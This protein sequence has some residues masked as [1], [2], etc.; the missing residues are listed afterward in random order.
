MGWQHE[1]GPICHI[2]NMWF[3]HLWMVVWP[4]HLFTI[5]LVFWGIFVYFPNDLVFEW[6][7]NVQLV[8]K[9]KIFVLVWICLEFEEMRNPHWYFPICFFF[10]LVFPSF[11]YI[12]GKAFYNLSECRSN[13]QSREYT[14]I[15]YA[16]TL[17]SRKIC[18][19]VQLKLT[20]LDMILW[21]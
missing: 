10:E 14:Q 21:Q 20:I 13:Q 17:V 9:L 4:P 11:N 15:T 3:S 1:N 2:S 12:R 16:Y 19:L 8:S 18:T 5:W 6:N 7:S